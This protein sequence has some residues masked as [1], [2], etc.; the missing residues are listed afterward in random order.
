MYLLNA[1]ISIFCDLLSMPSPTC[2]VIFSQKPDPFN[3]SSG[4]QTY[5]EDEYKIIWTI[6]M[7]VYMKM[8]FFIV[9]QNL[10]GGNLFRT[11]TK[12]K[13][14]AIGFFWILSSIWLLSRAKMVMGQAN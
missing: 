8:V 4:K 11:R 9:G 3:F 14:K 6:A 7:H 1:A 10:Q 5:C 13:N 2:C 12:I